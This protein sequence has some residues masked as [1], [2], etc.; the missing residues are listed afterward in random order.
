MLALLSL[1]HNIQMLIFSLFYRKEKLS[2]TSIS[3][4]PKVRICLRIVTRGDYP[5]MVKESVENILDLMKKFDFSNFLIEVL[6]NKAIYL[7][8]NEKVREIVVPNDYTTLNGSKYKA[9]YDIELL[10]ESF[11]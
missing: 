11:L 6:A 1:P 8:R 5:L 4:F 7:P 10:I 3:F 2:R 9:R